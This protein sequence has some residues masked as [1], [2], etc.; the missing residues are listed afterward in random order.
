MHKDYAR[1]I[2]HRLKN[3]R[4]VEPLQDLDILCR[5]AT[6]QFIDFAEIQGNEKIT[7]ICKTMKES[8][9]YG[10]NSCFRQKKITDKQRFAVA[11]FLLERFGNAKKVIS[12]VYNISE[13]EVD[14]TPQEID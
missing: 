7:S 12:L 4:S 11:K 6:D 2:Y 9:G 1:E 5:L 3:P 14:L 8:Y 10:T 13:S